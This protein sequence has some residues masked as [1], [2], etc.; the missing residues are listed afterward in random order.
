M[1]ASDNNRFMHLSFTIILIL[2]SLNL[3]S[4]HRRNAGNLNQHRPGKEDWWL[5]RALHS[6]LLDMG[7]CQEGRGAKPTPT[8]KHLL[9][10]MVQNFNKYHQNIKIKNQK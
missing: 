3:K 6:P 7:T 4:R 2:I 10:Y 8:N 5:V 9:Q 1:P